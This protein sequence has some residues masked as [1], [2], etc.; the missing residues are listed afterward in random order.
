MFRLSG[1]D[2][3]IFAGLYIHKDMVINVMYQEIFIR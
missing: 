3:I 1:A 2:I